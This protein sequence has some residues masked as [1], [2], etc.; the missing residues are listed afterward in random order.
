MKNADIR[1]KKRRSSRATTN[2]S[3][4]LAADNVLNRQFTPQE[5][6]LAWVADITYFATKEGWLYLAVVIDLFSRRIVGW[7]IS[8][9]I[10]ANLVLTALTMATERR[11]PKPGLVVHTDRGSQ[12]GC[13][14]YRQFIEE[15]G[16]IP[17]MSRKRDCW[18]N[19]VA[20]SFFASLKVELKS[21]QVWATRSEARSEIFEY[22][23]AWYN[24]ERRHSTIGYVSPAQFEECRRVA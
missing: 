17:S 22:I 10:D 9:F 20:E 5:P 23:E 1:G 18:D 14:A 7:S 15:R 21:E 3:S 24:R 2:A 4:Y 13:R 11:N 6:N 19:A 16:I 12:Y 8:K